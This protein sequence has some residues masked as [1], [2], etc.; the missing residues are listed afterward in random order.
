MPESTPGHAVDDL[1]TV[2]ALGERELKSA[3]R[4][5]RAVERVTRLVARPTT[6]YVG[7]LFC[8]IWIVDN[9]LRS[10]PFDP[11]P[12]F[13]LQGLIGI[14]AATVTTCVLI[15]QSRQQ[16]EAERRASLQLHI[17]L[18]AEQKATKIISLLEELRRDLPGVKNRT[19]PVADELQHEIDARALHEVLSP[20]L[21]PA[22]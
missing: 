5:Q 13:D 12:F 19:D 3:N 14:Y 18:V 16:A 22:D 20:D 11:T 17:N 10:S 4:H 8:T 9:V 7:A 21:E 1:S 15:A 6:L 2:L